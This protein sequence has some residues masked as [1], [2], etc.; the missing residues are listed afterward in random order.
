MATTQ[1]FDDRDPVEALAEEFLLRRRNGEQPTVREYVDAYPSLAE[2]I[3]THFPTVL[4]LEHFKSCS[5]SSPCSSPCGS[6]V[7]MFMKRSRNRFSVASPSR[8]SR[9]I[10]Y[11]IPTNFIVFT[12]RLEPRPVC[13][14]PTSCL[15]S[16]SDSRTAGIIL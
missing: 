7:A 2:G 5:L 6:E 13:I 3:R 12:A 4:M 11:S 15:S 16:V 9:K 8:F 1:T 10:R 14:T